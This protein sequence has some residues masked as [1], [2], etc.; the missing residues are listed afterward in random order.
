V[1]TVHQLILAF[2]STHFIL[3]HYFIPPPTMSGKSTTIAT[4]DESRNP[5][6]SKSFI[7][8][9]KKGFTP[10]QVLQESYI[11]DP[12]YLE[13][14]VLARFGLDINYIY[15]YG[16]IFSRI[17]DKNPGSSLSIKTRPRTNSNGATVETPTKRGRNGTSPHSLSKHVSPFRNDSNL[18]LM[19]V[20]GNWYKITKNGYPMEIDPVTKEKVRDSEVV[21]RDGIYHV[22]VTISSTATKEWPLP[23]DWENHV[24]SKK[25]MEH[26]VKLKGGENDNKENGKKENGKKPV[27]KKEN[28]KKED[29]DFVLDDDEDEDEEEDDD[30]DDVEDEDEVKVIKPS[31]KIMGLPPRF[32]PI[33]GAKL[34]EEVTLEDRAYIDHV[35][36]IELDLDAGSKDAL[37]RAKIAMYECILDAQKKGNIAP[38]HTW[39]QNFIP[40]IGPIRVTGQSKV[41]LIHQFTYDSMGYYKFRIFRT[42]LDS[43]VCGMARWKNVDHVYTAKGGYEA[44]VP[45]S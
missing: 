21:T 19:V 45:R 7:D 20:N 1:I 16:V 37:Q 40:I 35:E 15:A 25:I 41:D 6:A 14:D 11:K 13:N 36:M 26:I 38:R 22:V 28:G 4:R 43:L 23:D 12:Q 33:T 30:D 44:N 24:Y 10:I 3:H 9:L 31:G 34:D 32:K 17:P 39:L 5:I 2:T 29:D 27:V 8:M 42:E 18:G